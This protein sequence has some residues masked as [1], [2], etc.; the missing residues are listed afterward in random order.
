MS[1]DKLLIDGK[2]TDLSLFRETAD[3]LILEVKF[4]C[5]KNQTVHFIKKLCSNY[6]IS[7]EKILLANHLRHSYLH[8]TDNIVFSANKFLSGTRNNEVFWLDKRQTKKGF[9]ESFFNFFK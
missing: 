6:Q 7:I 4:E 1:I 8:Q 3:N 5:L 9:F 2:E